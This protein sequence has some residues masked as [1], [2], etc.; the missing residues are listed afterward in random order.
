[1][2]PQ[3]YTAFLDHASE[4]WDAL[5][6]AR[7]MMPEFM[8]PI[9][10]ACGDET[11]VIAKKIDLLIGAIALQ[12]LEAAIANPEQAKAA[13]EFLRGILLEKLGRVL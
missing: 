9:A 2:T 1:M 5:A 8:T 7:G 3:E 10:K 11:I 12:H 13:A 4:P 6:R